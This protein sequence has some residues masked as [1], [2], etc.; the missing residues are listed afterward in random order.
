MSEVTVPE[1]QRAWRAIQAGQFTDPA[2]TRQPEWTPTGPVLPVLGVHGQCGASTVALAV[3]AEWAPARVVECASGPACGLVGAPTTELG[4]CGAGW[5]RG[6]RGEV[7]IDHSH[8]IRLDATEVP[9]PAGL[10]RPAGMTVVDVGWDPTHVL[11]VTSW[12]SMLVSTSRCVVLVATVSVP[13]LRRLENTLAVIPASAVV[14]AVVGPPPKRWPRPVMGS[15]GAF[16]RR[17]IDADRL[18]TVPAVGSLRLA[19]V[20]TDPLPQ[21]VLSAAGLIVRIVDQLS[22]TSTEAEKEDV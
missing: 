20:T 17:L 6:L 16:T 13:S 2:G 9:L 22:P 5:T 15:A 1:L 12:L 14:A 11:S 3:A 4:P 21:P 19:G 8:E 18:V 7:V 10:D